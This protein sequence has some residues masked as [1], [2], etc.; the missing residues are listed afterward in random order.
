MTCNIILAI[1]LAIK[2]LLCISDVICIASYVYC[3]RPLLARVH[4]D[5]NFV[6]VIDSIINLVLDA[7]PSYIYSC[8]ARPY[9]HTGALLLTLQAPH[10][11]CLY[12]NF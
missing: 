11:G 12:L 9:F 8:V 3:Y 10:V 5:G 2:V 1:L 4:M 6:L 7:V